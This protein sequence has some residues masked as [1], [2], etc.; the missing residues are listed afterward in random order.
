MLNTIHYLPGATI[1]GILACDRYTYYS[2]QRSIM[3]KNDPSY[4]KASLEA[5]E[6]MIT[7]HGD[8]M[9]DA[10][11]VITDEVY[12][13]RSGR[14]MRLQ[15]LLPAFTPRLNDRQARLLGMT[16]LPPYEDLPNPMYP[17]IVFIQGSAW[18]KQ[19]LYKALIRLS[20]YVQKG[21]AVASVE[22]REIP[23]D[24][25]PAQLIDV[26]TAI[27][28][29]RAN[30]D[31]FGID[32][33]RVAVMGN[34]SGGHLSQMT[35]LTQGMEEFSD[36]LYPEESDSVKCC[37]SF[38]GVSDLAHLNAAP[39]APFYGEISP[40][41]SAEGV[42]MGGVDL[43]AHPEKAVSASPVCYVKKDRP[44]PPVLLLH[45]DEDGMV[46][47]NQSARVYEA[48]KACGKDATLVK[49]LGAGH[50]IEFYSDEVFDIVFSFLEKHL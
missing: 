18:M 46:P 19:D 24:L 47:F 35:A 48:L 6:G 11:G 38:Y 27:R 3:N 10:S 1:F 22:Y 33:S 40:E 9:A 14:K 5:P 16:D 44:C 34:S 17:L 4:V 26:K 43:E 21:Y 29:M 13:E 41:I 42:L 25:W 49:V 45:G 50:G 39:R 8:P 36:G 32:K 28:Y 30:A 7:A 23:G 31:L 37:V 20:R 12:C 15:I 2:E